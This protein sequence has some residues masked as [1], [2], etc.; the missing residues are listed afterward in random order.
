MYSAAAGSDRPRTSLSQTLAAG[1]GGRRAGSPRQP[2][3]GC[4]QPGLAHTGHQLDQQLLH[5]LVADA[6]RAPLG[7]LEGV[8]QLVDGVGALRQRGGVAGPVTVTVSPL[9]L[10]GRRAGGQNPV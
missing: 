7:Q 10:P 6:G 2:V 9:Q 3:H 4:P 8:A 1:G 5:E